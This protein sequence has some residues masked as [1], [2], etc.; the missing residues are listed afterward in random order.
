MGEIY[1]PNIVPYMEQPWEAEAYCSQLI[2]FKK[3]EDFAYAIYDVSKLI[4]LSKISKYV[5]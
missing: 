4:H 3:F 5:K 1:D 2:P